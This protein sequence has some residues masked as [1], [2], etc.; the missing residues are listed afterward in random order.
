M[1]IPLV[2]LKKYLAQWHIATRKKKNPWVKKKKIG[3]NGPVKV[4]KWGKM[5]L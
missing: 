1:H 3:Q 2:P 4:Y 5:V